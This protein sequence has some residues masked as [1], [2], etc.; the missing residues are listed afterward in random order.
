MASAGRSLR[1]RAFFFVIILYPCYHNFVH[2]A[3]GQPSS[4]AKE[5]PRRRAEEAYLSSDQ[6][7]ITLREMRDITQK[8]RRQRERFTEKDSRTSLLED[9]EMRV[10]E[11]AHRE[12]VE[13]LWEIITNQKAEMEKS[14]DEGL[15][16]EVRSLRSDRQKLQRVHANT[17][18]RLARAIEEKD[19]T[20]ALLQRQIATIRTQTKRGQGSESDA[21]GD[22]SSSKL[23]LWIQDLTASLLVIAPCAAIVSVLFGR[24]TLVSNPVLLVLPWLLTVLSLCAMAVASTFGLFFSAEAKIMGGDQRA[25]WLHVGMRIDD[26]AGVLRALRSVGCL[27]LLAYVVLLA[28]SFVSGCSSRAKFRSLYRRGAQ[29]TLMTILCSIFLAF[30]LDIIS[31]RFVMPL[32]ETANTEEATA[33]ASLPLPLTKESSWLYFSMGCMFALSALLEES[34]LYE[35]TLLTKKIHPQGTCAPEA[36]GSTSSSLSKRGQ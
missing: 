12:Q 1:H 23:T 17:T 27:V 13:K 18:A 33:G 3:D 31:F 4:S 15:R 22:S 36:I 35:Q 6:D 24:K 14:M 5:Y 20:I 2:A 7:G 8:R 10:E 32:V 9:M 30:S 21:Y 11:A 28:V 26:W 34:S 25:Q 19:T 16:N 29:I